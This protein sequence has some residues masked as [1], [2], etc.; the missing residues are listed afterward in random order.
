VGGRG[1]GEVDYSAEEQVLA[2]R[3][4]QLGRVGLGERQAFG[5]CVEG[6]WYEG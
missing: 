2:L 3:R 4:R 1:R 5:W 6:G